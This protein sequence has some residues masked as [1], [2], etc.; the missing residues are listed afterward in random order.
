MTTSF[1]MFPKEQ[2]R[3]YVATHLGLDPSR[4]DTWP[5]TVDNL[6]DF[7]AGEADRIFYVE[8]QKLLEQRT[9]FRCP[10]CKRAS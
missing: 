3:A 2:R 4:P 9:T 7:V 6:I 5:E 8:T 10:F 1:L